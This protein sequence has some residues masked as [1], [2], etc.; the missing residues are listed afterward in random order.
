M[1]IS[2]SEHIRKAISQRDQRSV[3]IKFLDWV[4]SRPEGGIAVLFVLAQLLCIL[5]SLLWPESFRYLSEAN[6]AVTLKA[7]APLGI[8]A[9]GVGVLMIAGEYDLSVGALY[10]FLSIVCATISNGWGG[11]ISAGAVHAW[12]PFVALAIALAMGALIGSFHAF[13][14]L[15]FAIPSFIATL[16]G[17]LFWKSA[18]LFYHGAVALRFKPS[19]P[20]ATLFNGQVGFIHASIIWFGLMAIGFYVLLHHHKLG[21]HFYAVGGNRNAA[22]AIGIN[23]ARTKTIAFAITGMMAALAG[24]IA[25]TRVGSI[26]P[27]GGL[28]MELQAIAACVIGGA[29][30]TGGRGSVLGVVLGTALVYTI[31][32]VLLLARAPAYYFDGFVGMLIVIAAVMNAG[33]RN[34]RG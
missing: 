12:A 33:I 28:G 21:N 8:M 27:G 26:Q 14:T 4:R 5:V 9:L 31:Q 22:V 30:L 13:L 25:A 24:V 16:G 11:D 15:R 23:P 17:M 2:Q 34:S 18:T 32:D 1:A 3:S 19:E 6:V 20:F 10:S 7:I 29:A